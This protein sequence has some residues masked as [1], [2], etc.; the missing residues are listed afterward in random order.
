MTV[1]LWG[2]NRDPDSLD[3]VVF[4]KEHG[5]RPDRMLDIDRQPPEP[6]EWAQISLGLDSLVDAI[7]RRHP[8]F[9]RLFHDLDRL[10]EKTIAMRLHEHRDLIRAPILLTPRGA[11]AGFGERKWRGFL[12][13]R[14]GRG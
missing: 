6:R 9:P 12:E 10:E 13:V 8:E 11:V 1:T 7:D 5:V 3:A 14:K 4:L 2:R